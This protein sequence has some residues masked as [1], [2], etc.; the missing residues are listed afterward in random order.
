MDKFIPL[1]IMKTN[2]TLSLL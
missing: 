1:I 2:Q